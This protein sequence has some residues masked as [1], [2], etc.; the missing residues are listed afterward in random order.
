[1]QIKYRITL[2]F[3]AIVMLILLTLS[4]AIYYFSMTS[5]VAEYRERLEMKAYSTISL[6]KNKEFG[7]DIINKFNRTSPSSLLQKSIIVYDL[8]HDENLVYHD[9][10]AEQLNVPPSTLDRIRKERKLAFKAGQ[11]DV[12]GLHYVGS[13]SEYIVLVAAYDEVRYEWLARLRFILV[14]CVL[15]SV[16]IVLM[17]GY[18]FSLGLVKSIRDLTSQI[19]NISSDNFLHNLPVNDSKDELQVLTRTINDLLGRLK[20][21]FDTQSRF[22]ANA[23]HE[24]STPLA[25]ISSQLDIALQR[26]RESYEY[27]R[28]IKSV[29]DDVKN[30]NVLLKSLLELAKASGS[31]AGVELTAVRIDELLMRLPA[32]MKKI[33]ALYDVK[34]VFDEFP[35]QEE[36]FIIYGNEELLYTA[37][38]NFVHNACKFSK[39]NCATISLSFAD[40]KVII[41][42]LDRGPG[43]REEDLE[44]IFQPFYRVSDEKNKIHGTGLGLALA[45]RIIRLH[46]GAIIVDSEVGRGSIFRLF[47]PVES[48]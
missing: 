21:S 40:K 14:I 30:L 24:L 37:I 33:S 45:N 34:L 18:L 47:F 36:A 35:D 28:V 9:S 41:S 7:P 25:S 2:W 38:R 26:E 19:H 43:I 10:G 42:I 1:M 29:K 44:K 23:S 16:C 46:K 5:K 8:R 20:S 32:D 27:R 15:V 11:R 48:A 31:A 13:N 17:M 3:T 12:L 39:D 6:L 22:I 4:A